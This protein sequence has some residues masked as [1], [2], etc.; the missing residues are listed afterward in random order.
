MCPL[1]H[2][3]SRNGVIAPNANPKHKTPAEDPGHLEIWGR[4]AIR[5]SDAHDNSDHTNDKLIA[6]NESPTISVSE[7]AER[8]LPK[9][10]ANIGGGVD[11]AAEEWRVV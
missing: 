10:V 11:E 5:Q 3:R 1:R 4:D 8:E 9:D 2:D 6:V 7:I